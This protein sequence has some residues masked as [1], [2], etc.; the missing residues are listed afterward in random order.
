MTC[1]HEIIINCNLENCI[2]KLN[3]PKNLRHWQRGLVN[4]D[5]VSGVPGRTGSKMQ[6][7]YSFNKKDLFLTQTISKSDFPHL[8]YMQLESKG[9]YTIQKNYFKEVSENETV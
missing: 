1:T 9:L 3:N 4:F 5:F 2:R 6:L 7:H 8:L